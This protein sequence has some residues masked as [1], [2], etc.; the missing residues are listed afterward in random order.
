MALE[1]SINGQKPKKKGQTLRFELELAPPNDDS[2]NEFSYAHLKDDAL[3]KVH[4]S[5]F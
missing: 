3:T 2:T 4:F 1:A 5:P